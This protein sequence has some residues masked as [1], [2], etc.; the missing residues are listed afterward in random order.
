MR[1]DFENWE[2]IIKHKVNIMSVI[3]LS[4]V[5]VS[6]LIVKI[7]PSRDRRQRGMR[8]LTGLTGTFSES[9]YVYTPALRYNSDR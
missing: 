1:L 2:F 3:F 8:R 9:C 4:C 7:L 5:G 6:L